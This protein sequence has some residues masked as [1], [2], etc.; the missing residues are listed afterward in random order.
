[1]AGSE[2]DWRQTIQRQLDG[3]LSEAE[4]RELRSAAADEPALQQELDA[5]VEL[6]DL[7]GEVASTDRVDPLEELCHASDDGLAVP[8]RSSGSV[9]AVAATLLIAFAIWMARDTEQGVPDE[10][11]D[12]AVEASILVDDEPGSEAL[13]V[14]LPSSQDDVHVFWVYGT[15]S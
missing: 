5:F 7:I 2:N 6:Q 15:G 1:M 12:V 8:S 10:S 3:E 14:A 13:V 11:R 4:A 9:L